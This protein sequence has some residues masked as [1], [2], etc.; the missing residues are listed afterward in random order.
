MKIIVIIPA[1]N[2]EASIARVVKSIPRKVTGVSTIAV[3]VYDDGS[4]DKTV[5]EAKKAGADYVISHTRTY[6]L[7]RTF[8]DALH[9]ALALEA[10]IIVNTDADD[11]YDQQE[12]PKLVSPIVKGEYD[13][14]IGDRQVSNLEHMSWTKRNGN[15]LGSF[16]IRLLTGTGVTDASSGFRAF[17]AECA[18]E[19]N[20]LSEHTYTHEMIIDT[21]FKN[22]RIGNVPITFKKRL[23]GES[24]LIS[25]GIV[26]HLIKSGGTIVR[27][28]LLYK[29]LR[30]MT[31]I[32]TGFLLVGG[33]GLVRYF[34]FVF[35][36][37][38]SRGHIQ[39]LV[40]SS[41]FVAIGINILVLGFIADLISYNRRLIDD[42][43]KYRG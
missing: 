34:Y 23:D 11:Q 19:I 14:V 35:V 37:D 25:S 13:L 42:K 38:S 29:A 4:S 6:G 32:G 40:I 22:F 16:L 31:M 17:S 2:E 26:S 18:R 20:I 10:D 5:Q 24:R 36:N 43:E 9:K 15:R 12:I 21:H 1:L 3:L 30:V 28:I 27:S 33:L 7:A 39:S 8:K 41:I